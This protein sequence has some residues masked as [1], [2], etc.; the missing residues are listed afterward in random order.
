MIAWIVD[1]GMAASTI[2]LIR[3]KRPGDDLI[4]ERDVDLYE[5]RV[6]EVQGELDAAIARRDEVQEN[7]DALLP[8]QQKTAQET[9]DQAQVELDKTVI[10]A[11]I[12]GRISQFIL[13][14][15]D[16]VNPLLRPAG[17]IIPTD[18]TATVPVP[19]LIRGVRL[20][21]R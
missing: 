15:G 7:I 18:D 1:I 8:A 20:A 9:L 11:D 14:P 12:A 21:S 17:I 19:R 16:I 10:Y 3:R 4:S 13:Q 5:N 6:T 2:R